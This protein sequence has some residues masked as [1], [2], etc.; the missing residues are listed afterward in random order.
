MNPKYKVKASRGALFLKR[1]FD[2]LVAGMGLIVCLPLILI[3][4]IA[5]YA[6]DRGGVIFCQERIGHKGRAFILRKFRTMR[7]DAESSGLPQLYRR[8]DDRLTRVGRFLREH[9]L[10]EIPQFWN[11]LVGDMSVVGYRPERKFYID[12]IMELNPDYQYLYQIRPGLF[13]RATLYNGYTD[14]MEKMLIRLDMDLEYLSRISFAYDLDIL[15]RT[16]FSI[17]LGKKF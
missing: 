16:F 13:S 4:S 10:D 12:Q 14:T 11:V 2:I 9:H 7:M 1:A 6:E 17:I 8:G 3:I 5:I 15:F